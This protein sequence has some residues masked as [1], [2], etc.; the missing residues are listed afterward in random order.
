MQKYYIDKAIVGCISEGHGEE[1]RSQANDFKAQFGIIFLLLRTS[2]TKDIVTDPQRSRPHLQPG[3]L[4]AEV[5][6]TL[7]NLGLL[8]TDSLN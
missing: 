6:G 3:H 8:L 5:V 2:K 7:K 1:H 4:D